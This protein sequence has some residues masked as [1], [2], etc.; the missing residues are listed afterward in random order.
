MGSII[1]LLER[2]QVDESAAHAV[3]LQEG[4]HGVVCD[5]RLLALPKKL[6][7]PI[8]SNCRNLL[9]SI[10]SVAIPVPSPVILNPTPLIPNSILLIFHLTTS[11]P[12]STS[13]LVTTLLSVPV[14]SRISY[15]QNVNAKVCRNRTKN[16]LVFEKVTS[17]NKKEVERWLE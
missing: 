16:V 5:E 7:N 14:R 8:L 13:R 3:L 15:E 17:Q 4:L 12:I 1:E 11:I 2:P 9:I 6:Q 10:P